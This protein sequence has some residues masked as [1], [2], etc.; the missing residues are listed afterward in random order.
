MAPPGVQQKPQGLLITQH[1]QEHSAAARSRRWQWRALASGAALCASCTLLLLMLRWQ[2]VQQQ[3]PLTWTPDESAAAAAA[4]VAAA[5]ST[6]APIAGPPA[7]AG[8]RTAAAAGMGGVTVTASSS[9]EF[10]FPSLDVFGD[11]GDGSGAA[12]PD[13]RQ[14]PASE[15]AAPF[16]PRPHAACDALTPGLLAHASRNGTVMLLGG[17]V[18]G[19]PNA[20]A[21]ADRRGC[22]AASA[23]PARGCPDADRRGGPR[24]S[25][26]PALPLSALPLPH[27]PPKLLTGSR[28]SR[29]SP[30]GWATR[31]PRGLTTF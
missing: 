3:A 24:R 13:A 5:V 7:A 31:G 30:T 23:A 16:T 29:C 10:V 27:T 28:R 11:G 9:D 4:A 19:W 14:L 12:L 1:D 6:A 2:S 8:P 18:G 17:W 22:L 25:P 21:T 15:P 20:T 26:R